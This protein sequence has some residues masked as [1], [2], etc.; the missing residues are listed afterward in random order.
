MTVNVVRNLHGLESHTS[1]FLGTE[2]RYCET[3]LAKLIAK[4]TLRP[5]DSLKWS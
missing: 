4:H 1:Y 2:L 3:S 5:M